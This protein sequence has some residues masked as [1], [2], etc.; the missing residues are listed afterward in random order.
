MLLGESFT[1]KLVQQLAQLGISRVVNGYGPS[2]IGIWA[3]AAILFDETTCPEVLPP[4]IGYPV[5]GMDM[6]IMSTDDQNQWQL[7]GP[8]QKGYLFTN[9]G[10]VNVYSDAEL[11]GKR[12]FPMPDP[13]SGEEVCFYNT[14][15]IVAMDKHGEVIFIGRDDNQVKING[16][17]VVTDHV[18]NLL[19]AAAKN[20]F[21]EQQI[22]IHV[23]AVENSEGSK[24]LQA[25]LIAE[26]E[27]LAVKITS[28]I[29]ELAAEK[30][31]TY[32]KPRLG[33]GQKNS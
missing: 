20:L 8:E 28:A 32:M 31:A 6:R 11:N 3:S 23:E 25:Y 21:P 29:M 10:I 13:I 9:N 22:Q 27:E 33:C 24:F 17:L 14:G 5:P 16:Q 7:C 18:S 1:P 4:A 30:I 2:E 26:N 15:D 12:Y 19:S